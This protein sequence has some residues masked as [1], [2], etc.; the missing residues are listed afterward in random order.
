MLDRFLDFLF[1]HSKSQV[2]IFLLPTEQV[3]D[4]RIDF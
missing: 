1:L 3:C 4:R 2:A